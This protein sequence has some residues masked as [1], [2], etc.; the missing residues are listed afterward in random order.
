MIR[1][2]RPLSFI[3]GSSLLILLFI[4][5]PIKYILGNPHVVRVVGMAHG[6]LFIALVATIIVVAR[7]EHWAKG[8]LFFALVSSTVP[9]GMVF[10]ERKLKQQIRIEPQ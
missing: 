2:L 1:F 8:L 9:F 3:E 5:M 7:K 4:A 6:L 10:L